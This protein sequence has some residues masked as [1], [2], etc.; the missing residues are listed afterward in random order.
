MNDLP[1]A[2]CPVDGATLRRWPENVIDC[3]HCGTEYVVSVSAARP[4]WAF[5]RRAPFASLVVA[6]DELLNPRSVA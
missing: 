5:N 2:R 6:V 4:V 3:P 1:L